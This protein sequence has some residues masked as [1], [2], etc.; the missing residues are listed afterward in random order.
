MTPYEWAMEEV[1]LAILRL[2]DAMIANDRFVMAQEC[3][4]ARHVYNDSLTLYPTLQLH[5]AERDSFLGQMSLLGSQLER[6]ERLLRPPVAVE[7]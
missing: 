5:A 1:T 3:K 4:E 6:C 2:T 7:G